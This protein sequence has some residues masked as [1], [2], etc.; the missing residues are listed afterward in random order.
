MESLLALQTGGEDPSS[1][2]GIYVIPVLGKGRQGDRSLQPAYP[3]P[4]ILVRNPISSGK[5]AQWVKVSDAKPHDLSW[6]PQDPYDG[7]R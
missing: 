3:K 6:S 5:M 4:K 7:R 2:S 1:I